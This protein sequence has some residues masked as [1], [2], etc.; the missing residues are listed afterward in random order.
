MI[1]TVKKVAVVVLP[2]EVYCPSCTHTVPAD[3]ALQRRSA[4]TV[5]GQKCAQCGSALDAAAVVFV[6]R[7]A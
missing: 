6:E 2:G 5:P 4:H 3:V 7:A 1:A